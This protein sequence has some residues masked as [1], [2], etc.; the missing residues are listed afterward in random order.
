M[1]GKSE[2]KEER[3]KG[4]E[5]EITKI[6]TNAISCFYIREVSFFTKI[7]YNALR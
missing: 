3:E 6:K 2:K 5:H 1:D 7:K 4:R